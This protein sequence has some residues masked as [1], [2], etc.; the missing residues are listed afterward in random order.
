MQSDAQLV[1]AVL[2]GRTA[3]YAQLVARYERAVLA[4]ALQVLHDP[5]AGEDVAQ[6]S[7]LAAYEQLGRLRQPAAFG[8]W[9]I[10][11]ARRRALRLARQRRRYRSLEAAGTIAAPGGNGL[12]DEQQGRLL[13]AVMR[14][15]EH[16]RTVILLRHF[17]GHEIPAIAEITHRPVGTVTKQLSRAHARLRE[18]LKD[19]GP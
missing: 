9:L 5:G 15:A 16:E 7:F 14:L 11:I 6:D 4:A 3:A 19:A 17:E 13:A 18:W 2:A 1:Q 8:G 12:L 10:R